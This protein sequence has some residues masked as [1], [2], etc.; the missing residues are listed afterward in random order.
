[1]PNFRRWLSRRRVLII[2]G[3]LALLFA[4]LMLHPYPRQ[5]LF[6]PKIEGVP[7]CVWEDEIRLGAHWQEHEKHWMTKARRWVGFRGPQAPFVSKFRGPEMLSLL[8]QLSEDPDPDVREYATVCLLNDYTIRDRAAL[9]FMRRALES[10]DLYERRAAAVAIWRIEQD[11]SVI[12]MLRAQIDGPLERD[13]NHA[14]DSLASM[15]RDVPDPKLLGVI[16]SYA[17][18]SDPGVRSSVLF[19][20]GVSPEGIPMLVEGLND[21]DANVRACAATQLQFLR[22]SAVKALPALERSLMDEDSN[23]RGTAKRAIMYI[24]WT[25]YVRL[26]DDGKIK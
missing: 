15:Y 21:V 10:A 16:H 17:K 9:P 26:Q 22:G 7:W 14:A 11:P 18:H 25:C 3:I 5:S 1:M 12:L 23:V 13:R 6:G 4:V 8:L 24:D 2:L 20:V 19:A